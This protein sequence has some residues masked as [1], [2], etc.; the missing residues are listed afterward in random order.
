MDAHEML[1]QWLQNNEVEDK[2][3]SIHRNTIH[4]PKV[5]IAQFL[6]KTKKLKSNKFE[7]IKK[8]PK[9]QQED[10][11]VMEE[12]IR[13]YGVID[14]D[15]NDVENK[16][17]AYPPYVGSK[18][19]AVEATLDLHHYNEKEAL[20]KL[21]NFIFSC[22]HKQIRVVKIIHGKG[23]HSQGKPKIKKAVKQ[24]ITTQGKKYIRHYRAADPSNGGTG[25]LI[26]WLQ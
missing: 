6:D 8:I 2:D 15:K 17:K 3:N 5:P 23:L 13:K 16:L 20:T 7:K 11:V 19:I 24:W 21:Q 4:P 9:F 14:K 25:A 26:V 18:F 12:W 10:P 22:F 1:N